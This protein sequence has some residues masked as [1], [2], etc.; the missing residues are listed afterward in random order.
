[1]SGLFYLANSSNFSNPSNPSNFQTLQTLQTLKLQT[2]QNLFIPL[3]LTC[4]RRCQVV[5]LKLLFQWQ[6]NF[7]TTTRNTEH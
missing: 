2:L 3:T 7:D 1:L 4:L 5:F 6:K